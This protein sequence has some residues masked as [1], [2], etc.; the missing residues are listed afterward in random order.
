MD[1]HAIAFPAWMRITLAA[2][3]VFL[4]GI[5]QNTNALLAFDVKPNLVLILLLVLAFFISDSVGYLILVFISGLTLRFKS[6][7][8]IGGAAVT[9]LALFIFLL[10]HIFYC[11]IFF[12][13]LLSSKAKRGQPNGI[14]ILLPKNPNLPT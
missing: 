4:A 7:F 8:E 14:Q 12:A 9:L 1:T 3:A 13:N 2:L 11:A 5:V 6:G 10:R